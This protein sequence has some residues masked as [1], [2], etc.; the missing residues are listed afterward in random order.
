MSELA[1]FTHVLLVNDTGSDGSDN[2]H[3]EKKWNVIIG[4]DNVH[5]GVFKEK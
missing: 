1:L 2:E 3:T 4:E 5:D